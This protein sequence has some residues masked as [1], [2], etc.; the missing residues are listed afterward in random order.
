MSSSWSDFRTPREDQSP[1]SSEAETSAVLIRSSQSYSPESSNS[2]ESLSSKDELITSHQHNPERRSTSA[3]RQS[4]VSANQKIMSATLAFNPEA[5]DKRPLAEVRI[6]KLKECP[7]LTEGR[8]DD[9]LFQQWSIACQRYQKHSGKKPAEIV[10][11]VADGMLEPRFVAWYHTNQSRINAMN[12]DKYLEEFQK[13]PLPRN[14]QTKVRDTILGSYQEGASF[15]DWVVVVQNLTARLKNTNSE[16]TLTDQSLKAHFESHMHPDLRRKVDVKRFRF[17]ELADWV[18]EVTEL[19][20]ELAEDRA[21]TQAIINASNAEKGKCKPLAERISEPRASSASPTTSGTNTPRLKLAKLTDNK[22]RLLAE[23]QG[24]TRCR[25]FYCD[26][27][28]KPD[29]CPMKTTNTWPNPKT[30]KTLTPAMALAAKPKQVAGLAYLEPDEDAVMRDEDT[31]ESYTYA[32]TSSSDIEAPLSA[33]HM[34][35]MLE[36]TG[37]TISSFPLS[38]RVILDNGCPSTVIS[39]E[40]VSKL[41]LRRFPLAK[42]EDNLTSLT[43]SPLTCTKYVRLEATVGKGAWRSKVFRAKVN[44]GLPVPLLLGI[45]FL[46]AEH[47]V[48]DIEANTATDKRTGFN[49][50]HPCC[51]PNPAP[52]PSAH[53]PP[54]NPPK[55]R[56]AEQQERTKLIHRED[57]TSP[58]QV[59]AWVRERIEVLSLEE[60]LEKKDAEAKKTYADCFPSK[61]PRTTD[62]VVNAQGYSAPKKFHE[63]WKRLLEEHLAAGRLC[64]SSSEFA[65]PAFCI[66]KHRDGVP[67][68]TIPPRWVN[69]YQELNQNTIRDSFPLPRVDDILA[70]C[71]KGKIFGKIDMTNA[72]FPTRVHPDDIHLTAI[73]TPWGLYKWV[74]M[75]MGGCNAP[76]THQRRMTDAL[77]GLIGVVCHVYLD[78]IIIWSDTIKEHEENLRLGASLFCNLQKSTLFARE[79]QFLGHIISKKGIRP[80]L[81]KVNQ[82]AKWPVP[83]T[84][85]NV[86][87]FLGLT[88]YLSPFIPALAEHTSVLSPLTAKEYDK[89]FPA[90]TE[91]HQRA[92]DAMQHMVTNLETLTVIDYED[93][94]KKIFVTTDA[95]DRR[96][97]AILSFG[98]TW[99]SARPVAYDSYQ[100]NVAQWNYPTHKRELLAIVKALKKWCTSLLGVKFKVYTDHR[101][102]EYF[103]S[104]KQMS[105][106]QSRW[107]MFL[108]DFDFEIVYIQGEDNSAADALS[109]MLT[110]LAAGALHIETEGTLLKEIIAGY[111]KDPFAQQVQEG[112]TKGSIVG[113]TAEDGLIYLGHHLLVPNSTH[114]RELLY[115]LAHDTLGHYRFEKSYATLQDSYYWPHMRQD[116]EHA[117]IPSCGPCQRNEDRTTKPVGPLHPLPVPD[118]RLSVVGIDFIGLLPE[119]DGKDT[120]MTMTDLLGAEVCLAGTH[121][122]DMAAQITL[123][124][125]NKWYCENGLMTQIVSDR[126]HLFV[127]DMW[128]ELHKLTG[129]K[130]KM[131]TS[132]H[133]ETDGG[134]ERSNKTVV[135]AIRYLVDR[136]QKGWLATL[137]RVQFAIMNTVNSSTG[138]SPFQLKTG[139]SPRVIPPLASLLIR[140]SKEKRT[141]HELIEKLQT[142]VK[143]AQDNLLAAKVQQAYHA[144]ARC[145]DEEAYEVGDLVMLA[146]KHCR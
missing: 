40:L 107:A 129:V 123:V 17:P 82:V 115:N 125:F 13:F 111:G 104:Q 29:A 90:W 142:D 54:S 67:D 140:A 109:R 133:P 98:K 121:S 120:I 49:I 85:T 73:R 58:S 23:H 28:R 83:T 19:D 45:P 141:A 37:P 71:G 93:T 70:D 89:N 69:D 65:S 44:V 124:L 102:L 51:S 25:T 47:L 106:R 64:P 63:P 143:E 127:S 105:Q 138:F 57:Y 74:V 79:L 8:M 53:T 134:S 135:Q 76:S 77:R 75:P 72:F 87:G 14:W 139:R 92:F 114:V 84:A 46:L 6:T 56:G 116:L 20:E 5:E 132:Y 16:H 130:L 122:K 112:I 31:D 26:H 61:L 97:G 119:E 10:A 108:A 34:T 27:A 22:K 50:V 9:Y 99:E 12:L 145:A 81:R 3:Y 118:D 1:T 86:R 39:D 21:Q 32:P 66:P 95:S 4:T 48:L 126:D 68:F 88:R 30:T 117:Y 52:T 60:T 96:T 42:S 36:V 24:C 18:A 100:L 33:P 128:K 137:S 131:L 43:D 59:M 11:Y 15:A 101:T 35:A 80:D 41:G 146:M 38:V 110:M 2:P 55:K 62:N 94:M 91:D 103:Q 136:D 113:A 78:D 7:M 144:N